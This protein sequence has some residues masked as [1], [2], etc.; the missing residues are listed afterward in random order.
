MIE[1]YSSTLNPDCYWVALDGVM[2]AQWMKPCGGWRWVDHGIYRPV[3][4]H[5]QKAVWS[6]PAYD[7]STLF[8]KEQW[9]KVKQ[10]G[11]EA[12]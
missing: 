10:T 9:Q 3:R 2:V 4:K 6:G 7:P 12:W 8:D 11:H 1:Y 5:Y